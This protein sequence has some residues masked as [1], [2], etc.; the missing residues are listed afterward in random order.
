MVVLDDGLNVRSQTPA[1]GEWLR[2]LLPPGPGQD[3]VP[4]AV[5]NVAAQLLAV[6]AGV[7]HPAVCAGKAPRERDTHQIAPWLARQDGRRRR[8]V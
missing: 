6:E 8:G 4:A 1:S 5:Y 7:G 2:L 3:T